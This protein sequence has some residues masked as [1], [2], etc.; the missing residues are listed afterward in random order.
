M[1]LTSSLPPATP[2]AF[3]WLLL[4]F[5]LLGALICLGLSV[6]G[7]ARA[8][9]GVVAVLA[10]AGASAAALA[11]FGRLLLLPPGQRVLHQHLYTLLALERLH[12][13]VALT[14]DA[15]A[16]AFVLV[17]TLVGTLIHLFAA[18]YMHG[19]G[20]YARFFAC[21]NL[22]VFAMLLLVLGDSLLLCF[23][24]WEGV[25]LCSY[26]LI[27]YWFDQPAS[28]PAAKKAFIA[29]RIGDVGFVA[30][31][32]LLV[33]T[34]GGAFN[35]SGPLARAST[36]TVAGETVAPTLNFRR[37]E[38]LVTAVDGG[39]PVVAEALGAVHL[40]GVPVVL[41]V[42]LG[43]FLGMSGKS[44]Q[45]PLYLWLP[46][47]M[48]GPTPVSALIHAATMVT[49]G[50]YLAARLHFLLA[51][52][53]VALAVLATVGALTALVGALLALVQHDIKKLLAY[54]T[55]SQLGYMF[56]GLGVGAPQAAVFHVVTHACFKACLFLA[57]GSL[58]HAMAHVIGHRRLTL[59]H[60]RKRLQADPA[61]PQDLRNFHL[62]GLARALPRTRLAYLFGALA[63]AGLPVASGFF[64]KDEI[65][66]RALHARGLPGPLL[67]GV[68]L[69]TAGLTALY[70]ARSYYLAF[71]GD[72]RA[73][74]H[75][76]PPLQ[77]GPVVVLGVAALIV[78]PLLGWPV[79]WGG[80]PALEH[81]L[82]PAAAEGPAGA[83]W[84]QLAG[85]AVALFG[86][87]TG[88]ALYRTGRPHQ[89][90]HILRARCDGLHRL[91]WNRLYADEV[92]TAL[93]V[94]PAQDFSR[95][96][97]AVDR[98]F[99]EGLIAALVAVARTCAALGAW[100][101]RFIVDG[102][103]DGIAAGLGR[104][105]RQLQRVQT[106]RLNHYTLGITLGAAVLVALAWII[107]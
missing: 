64:S 55:I 51:L 16:A 3:L 42:C 85:A 94:H 86:W 91:L 48:A 63:L 53:P 33:A 34:L 50:I 78:G 47:A 77:T 97:A 35:T 19:D 70:T 79:A 28:G 30:A 17:I 61:D 88:R 8:H 62:A 2:D 69:F 57:A 10:M 26:L 13:D 100:L 102:L 23:F 4:A 83:V 60:T 74:D 93:V 39:Q 38:A 43:F 68:G 104:A 32:L 45:I 72:A 76:P 98:G 65:L 46:D 49:A 95:A 1:S 29:N 75:E 18:G 31:M 66:W 12:V 52:A 41:L 67:Y 101:D 73:R 24:G 36:V 106:G 5:P 82:T 15:L 37:L 14:F 56:L 89:V 103:I 84:G 105:G 87:L 54:S 44:A 11:A 7:R 99:I 80:H 20:G 25:G 22:F 59:N 58:I 21:L 40:W 96:A 90:L 107:R 71:G 27:G 9:A 92:A 6:S 81:F